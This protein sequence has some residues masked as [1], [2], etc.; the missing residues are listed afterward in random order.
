MNISNK[1]AHH[2]LSW[3]SPSPGFMLQE[4]GG[5]NKGNW[6]EMTNNPELAGQSNVVCIARMAGITNQFYRAVQR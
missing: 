4:M 1:L 6:V 3:A 2:N 5:L